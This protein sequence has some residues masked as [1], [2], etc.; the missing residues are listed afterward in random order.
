MQPTRHTVSRL[1]PTFL[2]NVSCSC[3]R[4]RGK[5]SVEVCQST[6]TRLDL[7]FLTDDHYQVFN[8][9][10]LLS[11]SFLAW[12]SASWKTR[13]RRTTPRP[14][15]KGWPASPSATWLSSSLCPLLTMTPQP[16][17]C[18]LLQT[19]PGQAD[20]LVWVLP[21]TAARPR[22]L[23]RLLPSSSSGSKH[24]SPSYCRGKRCELLSVN[25]AAFSGIA[26]WWFQMI[27]MASVHRSYFV[28]E[29]AVIGKRRQSAP[30]LRRST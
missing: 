29:L 5:T 23:C 10:R 1:L 3:Y 30:Y 25:N 18:R 14:D 15:H 16:I 7:P 8:P 9:F 13:W 12:R 17:S 28:C 27:F 6:L 21:T 24:G 20:P 19:S 11:I 26:A 4:P 2:V 22:G